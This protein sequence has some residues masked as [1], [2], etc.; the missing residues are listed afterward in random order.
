MDQQLLKKYLQNQ[1]TPAEAAAVYQSL[2]QHPELLDQLLP[3]EEWDLAGQ[4]AEPAKNAAA[5]FSRIKP[6]PTVRMRMEYWS[7]IAAVFVYAVLTALSFQYLIPTE[8]SQPGLV[9]H[10]KKTHQEVYLKNTGNHIQQFQL[11]DG[12]TVKL[13]PNSSLRYPKPFPAQHRQLILSGEARFDV[14]PDKNRPFSV[15]SS[16]IKTTAL[17]TSFLVRAWKGNKAEVRL[18]HGKVR[19]S[20][21]ASAKNK[22]F[23][24]V[25][26]YPGERFQYLSGQILVERFS[27]KRQA[28]QKS[29]KPVAKATA[30]MMVGGILEFDKTPLPQVCAEL[31]ERY[32]QRINCDQ[33]H[34]QILL[35]GQFNE[36]D[37]LKAILHKI[38]RLN[39]LKITL[40]ADG[41]FLLRE[42]SSVLNI[43]KTN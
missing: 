2:Q 30:A 11:E 26:L 40:N 18:F 43:E 41:S 39:N 21:G 7:Q 24:A 16:G 33:V 4:H 14:A 9:Q 37:T 17:G 13:S 31:S 38:A 20:T 28:L 27:P 5:I 15:F 35:T 29:K 1:C 22:A 32:G 12:S 23:K 6:R 10:A 25:I 19:V 8:K 42:E 34:K 36:S 3:K